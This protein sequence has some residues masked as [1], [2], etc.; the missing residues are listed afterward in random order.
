MIIGLWKISVITNFFISSDYMARNDISPE[1]TAA[2]ESADKMSYNDAI[3]LYLNSY[4][5]AK[6]A[7]KE[8]LWKFSRDFTPIV[9]MLYNLDF[10][11][12]YDSKTANFADFEF[13]Y[14]LERVKN[15]IPIN[16]TL[17]QYTKS[18]MAQTFVEGTDNRLGIDDLVNTNNLF[19]FKSTYMR[20]TD[21][22]LPITN[23]IFTTPKILSTASG[24]N[25]FSIL[26]NYAVSKNCKDPELAWDFMKFLIDAK[27]PPEVKGSSARAYELASFDYPL[28]M[29]LGL[30]VNRENFAV[31]VNLQ[32]NLSYK[33]AL[34]TAIPL[35]LSEDE[36]IEAASDYL[37]SIVERCNT[38]AE[39]YNDLYTENEA[40]II[41]DDMYLYLTDQQ[42][43][44][45]T[46]G[47]I[48]N[49]VLLW[50]SE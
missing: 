34:D 5:E 14:M 48:Q 6:A 46:M 23:R 49:K 28:I 37:V 44:E 29:G 20:E 30:S 25:S 39:M 4:D 27:Q 17:V 18:K 11:I 9:Y 43:V 3:K 7:D 35:S 16:K 10:L 32:T 40:G 2:F 13:M 19:M 8:F 38:T 47:N 22:L 15:D 42:S 24:N 21:S 31:Y 45:K 1:I 33:Y 50:L 41:W 12:D 26:N 36:Y